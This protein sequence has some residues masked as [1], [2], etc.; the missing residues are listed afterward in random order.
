MR[1]IGTAIY[2][3]LL[4][5]LAVVAG[6]STSRNTATSRSYQALVTRYNVYFN[7][8]EAY[9]K[10]YE[11]Q[12]QAKK[13]NLLEI[14]D[15]F[16]ISDPDVLKTGSGDYDLAIEKAQKSI[17]L[18]SITAKPKKKKGT[19]SEADKQWQNKNEYNP[20]L[21]LVPHGRCPAPEG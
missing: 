5:L 17:K 18:H 21:C 2:V 11:A 10:G 16:P 4:P 9:K 15:L 19:P 1:R 3:L 14:L 7:G 8:N 12:E 13:D 20:F 6:C